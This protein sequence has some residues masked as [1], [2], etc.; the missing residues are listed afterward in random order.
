[1]KI[2]CIINTR[3]GPTGES[4]ENELAALFANHGVQIQIV[5]LT[6]GNSPKAI[7]EDAIR[8]KY[9]VIVA[10]GGDGTINGVASAVVGNNAM[11]SLS[12][13]QS[14]GANPSSAVISCSAQ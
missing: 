4:C 3:S 1:M 12:L 2:F 5:E 14:V 9:D 11:L 6:K 13:S 10:A 8:Q 7:A